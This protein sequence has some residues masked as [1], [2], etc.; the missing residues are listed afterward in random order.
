MKKLVQLTVL[1]L[2]AFFIQAQAQT[3][4]VTT[5]EATTKEGKVVILKSDGTWTFKTETNS[6]NNVK[7]ENDGLA[8]IYFYRVKEVSGIDNKNT[9]VNLNDREIFKMPQSRFIGI[10]LK[11]GNY[12]IKM[13]QKQS[14]ILLE[15]EAGKTYF[16]RVSETVAGFGYNNSL[17]EMSEKLAVFQMRELPLLEDSKIKASDL[18][19]VKEKPAYK[20]EK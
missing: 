7:Q 2:F 16:V 20:D 6:D 11:A 8:T 4:S 5:T 18:V 14:E 9:G 19:L 3:E 13:R 10:K 12:K 17:M 1:L 15:V